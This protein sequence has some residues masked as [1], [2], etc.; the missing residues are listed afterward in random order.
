MPRDDEALATLQAEHRVALTYV[1][2]DGGATGYPANPNGSVAGIAGICNER[3]NVFGLMPH[4]EDHVVPEQ[5]PRCARGEGGELGLALFVQG[6]K[7]ANQ[8]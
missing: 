2:R 3:G 1:E 8:V 6:I 7:Y 4:P 5:H